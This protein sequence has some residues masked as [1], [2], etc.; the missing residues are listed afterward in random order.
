M[1]QREENPMPAADICDISVKLVSENPYAIKVL[2]EG[3]ELYSE[4]IEAINLAESEILLES[5]IFSLDDVGRQF[6][7]ALNCAASRN[8][9][10]RIHLDA[11]GSSYFRHN[12]QFRKLLHSHIGLRW[13]HRWNWRTPLNFNIR[14]HRKLLV[15]D[16]K[17]VFI[18]GFNIH[19]ESSRHLYGEQRW[20]DTHIV[21]SSSASEAAA[22]F[23]DQW[24]HRP[25]KIYEARDGLNIMPNFSRHCRYLLRCRLTRIIAD[26]RDSILVTTPY[27]LP[28]EFVMKALIKAVRR[29]VDIR[30]LV[31]WQSDHPFING[32]ARHYYARLVRE[33]IRVYAFRPRMLHAK[34]MVVD[35]RDIMVGSANMDYRSLFTNLELVCL[36]ASK[37]VAATLTQQFEQDCQQAERI[38]TS[39]KPVFDALWFYRPLVA[40]FKHLC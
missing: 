10:I 13:F 3:D 38:G 8:V 14:N 9:A 4:M 30:L 7:A 1:P 26:A 40:L 32:M 34:T 17:Q 36:F 22:Y 29:G 5:Y 19:T 25:R 39:A 21:T 11:V 18:G 24:C 2:T 20:R 15:V 27:F 31:P 23:E 28:D 6:I 16:R 37:A 12:S 33:S 35:S